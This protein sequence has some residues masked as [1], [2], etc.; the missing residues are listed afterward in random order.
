MFGGGDDAGQDD[1]SA[2]IETPLPVVAEVGR[3]ERLAWEKEA[4]GVF[5]SDHPFIDAARFFDHPK[6]T[7]TSGISAEIA[8]K[9]VTMAGIVAA[10]R[11]ITTRKGD[12]MV[13]ATLE[14]LYGSVEVVGFPRTYQETAELWQEDAILIV[15]GK[16]D[17][18]D[19][20]LQIIAEG[21]EAWTPDRDIES[22]PDDEVVVVQ[23]TVVVAPSTHRAWRPAK[24]AEHNG[25]GHSNGSS[26]GNGNG[27]ANGNG[28]TNGNGSKPLAPEVV[29]RRLRVLVNRTENPSADLKMLERL[30]HLL[31]DEGASPYEVIVAMPEGRFR[32][33]APDCRTR[34]T[35]DLMRQIK[36]DFGEACV[37]VERD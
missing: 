14:D 21:L 15:Q 27:H 5:L 20:R 7:V 28:H 22:I 12:T 24:S 18:R 9:Q 25:N 8:E 23:P 36:D 32:V 26:N 1:S 17:A 30:G 11:R 10:V 29:V 33:S 37:M 16:V 31:Q 13:V 4:I 3:R 6:Y 34:L 19:D 35:A 2:M